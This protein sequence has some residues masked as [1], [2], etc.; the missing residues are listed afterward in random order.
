V[1]DCTLVTCEKVPALDPDDRMLLHELR[2]RGVAVSIEVWSDPTVD[3]AASRLCVLRSTWDYHRRYQD[4]I[5]WVEH[6]AAVTAIRN[7]RDLLR[8]NAHKSYLREL[9]LLGVPVVP[10]AWVLQGEASDVAD[11]AESR[12]WG[13]IVIKPSHGAAAH[14]VLLVRREAELLAAGQAH[15][16]CLVQTQ[17]ALV[18]PYLKSVAAYGERALIFFHGR[19]SHAVAKKPFDTVL[20]VSKARSARVEATAE[21][22]GVAAKAVRTLPGQPLY[23]RVDLLRDDE[24]NVR[25]SEVELIEPGLYLA[26]HDPARVA[27]AD[28][29]EREL[30]ATRKKSGSRQVTVP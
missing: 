11:L 25:V 22:I 6:V 29:I 7:D 8:W 23:A 17:G 19:Y 28:A 10:T 24:D 20:A 9:E 21:E 26:V 2:A 4:F 5:T 1:I 13:D 12:G 16:D 30:D 18:Q 27:F 3:W 15:L 14:N